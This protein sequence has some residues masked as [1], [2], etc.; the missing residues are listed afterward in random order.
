MSVS[1]TNTE[2]WLGIKTI[3]IIVFAFYH[4]VHLTIAFLLAAAAN[5]SFSFCLFDVIQYNNHDSSLTLFREATKFQHVSL[6]LS[7]SLYEDWR[8]IARELTGEFASIPTQDSFMELYL[9]SYPDN[10]S[11][12]DCLI[13]AGL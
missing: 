10:Q 12:T 3:C 2:Q 5:F 6:S 9:I 4:Y 11:R 13:S 8:G 7:L 1:L